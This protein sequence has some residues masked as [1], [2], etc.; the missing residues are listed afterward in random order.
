MPLQKKRWIKLTDDN[1]NH[2]KICIGTLKPKESYEN[3]ESI[4][5]ED[6]VYIRHD[7][8]D[9]PYT[10]QNPDQDSNHRKPKSLAVQCFV[11][12]YAYVLP[13]EHFQ[14][15]ASEKTIKDTSFWDKKTEIPLGYYP[16]TPAIPHIKYDEN[17]WELIHASS[18]VVSFHPKRLN[19]I[20]GL[21][22]LHKIT[23]K[24][25]NKRL[26][27]SMESQGYVWLSKL[28]CSFFIDAIVFERGEK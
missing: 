9:K 21:I 11:P 20:L 1:Q 7:P 12:E 10:G 3:L 4:P 5:E 16:S 28:S 15:E 2:E 26:I 27:E 17:I 19:G 23:M 25:D 14:K 13:N 24:E 8:S 22:G 6:K 18:R